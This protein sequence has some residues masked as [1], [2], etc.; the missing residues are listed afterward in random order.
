MKKESFKFS[1]NHEHS[2]KR[3]KPSATV[4]ICACGKFR[5]TENNTNPVIEEVS[6]SSGNL[7]KATAR[8]WRVTEGSSF[9]IESKNFSIGS[10]DYDSTLKEETAKANAELIVKAV[11]NFDSLLMTLKALVYSKPD[12]ADH[13]LR[14]R[15]D[16]KR[17]IA[18]AG[19][20]I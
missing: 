17:A 12:N 9:F 8:P 11:N 16:A 4:E 6:H 13:Y 20:T 3:S 5:H 19:E 10:I 2:F 1:G 18:Q 7:D 15:N 14:A